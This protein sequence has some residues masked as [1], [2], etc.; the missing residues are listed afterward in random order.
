MAGAAFMAAPA[1]FRRIAPYSRLISLLICP[2]VFPGFAFNTF[3]VAFAHAP[4][5]V[6]CCEGVGLEMNRSLA[7]KCLEPERL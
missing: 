5:L 7:P 4:I 1:A 6:T 3:L 2:A